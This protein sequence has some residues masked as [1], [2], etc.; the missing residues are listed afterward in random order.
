MT[1]SEP[2]QYAYGVVAPGRADAA[3]GLAGVD[4]GHTV[5]ETIHGDIAA[6]VSRVDLAEFG[7]EPLKRNLEDL[8]W[9]ERV[10]RAHD[11][12]VAAAATGGAVVPLRLC[13]IFADDSGVRGMLERNRDHFRATLERLHGHAEWSVKLLADRQL[14]ETAARTSA[15]GAPGSDDPPGHAFFARK[16]SEAT[17]RRDA[18][19]LLDRAVQD[20]GARLR[21]HAAASVRLPPQNRK[22][23]GHTGEMILNAAYLVENA[24][25]T[26]FVQ[27]VQATA[28]EH[29]AHGVSVDLAGPFAP[30]NFVAALRDD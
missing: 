9:L 21:G 15:S 10:A 6:L 1:A 4:P 28:R 29:A 8:A 27:V 18:D 12:V 11:A 3:V 20:I 5:L 30:Y 17:A 13:T 23:S 19:D 16:R 26:A 7:S 22:L 2:G 25:A 14:A 24:R